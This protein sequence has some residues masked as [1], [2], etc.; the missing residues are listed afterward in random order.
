MQPKT[1]SPRVESIWRKLLYNR[2]TK[3]RKGS[4]R[5]LGKF[6]WKVVT[7]SIGLSGPGWCRSRRQATDRMKGVRCFRHF[8][9]SVLSLDH[10]ESMPQFLFWPAKMDHSI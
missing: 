7:R 3:G 6:D 8:S 5:I 1:A 2:P 10:K 4:S 9:T